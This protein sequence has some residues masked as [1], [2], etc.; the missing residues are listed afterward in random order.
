[1][2]VCEREAEGTAELTTNA[3]PR[4]I[5]VGGF[6]DLHKKGNLRLGRSRRHNAAREGITNATTRR[7]IFNESRQQ[8]VK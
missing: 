1:M 3:N 6:G 8:S 4:L 2:Y 5:A 7:R